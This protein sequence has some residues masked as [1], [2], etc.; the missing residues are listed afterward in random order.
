MRSDW[1]KQPSTSGG[2]EVILN[3]LFKMGLIAMELRIICTPG[4]HIANAYLSKIIAIFIGNMSTLS[5]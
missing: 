4:S 1:P 5:L 3:V 2:V